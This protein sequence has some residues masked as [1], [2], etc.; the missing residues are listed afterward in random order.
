MLFPYPFKFILEF[1]DLLL[2][3][4]QILPIFNILP[5]KLLKFFLT[6]SE[7]VI[8]FLVYLYQTTESSHVLTNDQYSIRINVLQISSNKQEIQVSV[9]EAWFARTEKACKPNLLLFHVFIVHRFKLLQCIITF[10]D[11]LPE[12]VSKFLN[13]NK[14]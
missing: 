7:V 12:I 2:H 14:F 11:L 5:F 9:G 13:E 6:F 10:L 1:L 8:K 4:L 3:M